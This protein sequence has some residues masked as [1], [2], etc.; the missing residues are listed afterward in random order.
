MNIGRL[1]CTYDTEGS[2]RGKTTWYRYL[3]Q[4]DRLFFQTSP[5][6]F[7]TR[8]KWKIQVNFHRVEFL[9][10]T[11]KF[12]GW[13]KNVVALSLRHTNNVAQ[14]NFASWPAWTATGKNIPKKLA[15]HLRASFTKT[16]RYQVNIILE[17]L[18]VIWSTSKAADE[19]PQT[20]SGGKNSTRNRFPNLKLDSLP[21]AVWLWFP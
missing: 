4:S 3:N 17:I 7:L 5:L 18:K 9:G 11:L 21:S 6:F 1:N 19:F 16:Q 14:G 8:L 2:D 10:T 12:G 20:F 15:S 13:K